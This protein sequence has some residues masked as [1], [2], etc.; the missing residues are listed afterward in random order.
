MFW[1]SEIFGA[2]LHQWLGE[3][4]GVISYLRRE[5]VRHVGVFG[6]SLGSLVAGLAAS[7]W[8]DLDFAAMLSPVGSHLDAIQHSSV[9]GRI[10][11]WM[12]NLPAAEQDLLTR[13]A[14]VGRRPRASRLGFFITRPDKIQPTGL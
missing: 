3:L 5:G 2:C 14:A 1:S 12:K 7:L 9:A 6:N 13:W 10:W 8:D 4:R 11:P